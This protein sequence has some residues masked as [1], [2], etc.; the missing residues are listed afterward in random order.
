M[1]KFYVTHEGLVKLKEEIQH[2]KNVKRPEIAGRV[3]VAREH[4]DLKEMQNIMPLKKSCNYYKAKST[5][6]K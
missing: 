4:G 5:R 1:S 3:Q 2:L 6:W